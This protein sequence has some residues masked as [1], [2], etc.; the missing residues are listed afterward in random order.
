FMTQTLNF[1]SECFAPTESN[2]LNR[3]VLRANQSFSLE[4][5]LSVAAEVLAMP[6]SRDRFPGFNFG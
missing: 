3:A 4:S 2:L 6:R 5:R 1:L